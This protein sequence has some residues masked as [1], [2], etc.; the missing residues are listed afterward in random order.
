VHEQADP[1][2]DRHKCQFGQSSFV[3]CGRRV[4]APRRQGWPTIFRWKRQRRTTFVQICTYYVH[5]PVARLPPVLQLGSSLSQ[6]QAHA[7][8]LREFLPTRASVRFLLRLV[9][10]YK[11]V[12]TRG[13]FE[14]V[15]VLLHPRP[16]ASGSRVAAEADPPRAPVKF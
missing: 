3:G 5:R 1:P 7:E 12:V 13:G 15:H 9:D 14:P 6:S 2:P 4:A 8:D 11:F 10:R 16:Q